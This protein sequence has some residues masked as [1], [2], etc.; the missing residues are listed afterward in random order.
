MNPKLQRDILS[1]IQ[2]SGILAKNAMA[3]LETVGAE[4]KQ[5]SALAEPLLNDLVRSGLVPEDRR[6]TASDLLATHAGTIQLLKA[7]GDKLRAEAAVKQASDAAQLGRG[8]TQTSPKQRQVPISQ[9]DEALR[10]FLTV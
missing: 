9:R 2:V 10:G 6:K 5:A 8:V 1:Y 4:R 3:E 7:A